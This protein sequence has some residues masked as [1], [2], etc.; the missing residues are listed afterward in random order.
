MPD[1]QQTLLRLETSA[2]GCCKVASCSGGL[3]LTGMA[4]IQ[5][6]SNSWRRSLIPYKTLPRGRPSG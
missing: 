6:S 4:G 5:Y 1:V 3:K 2:R